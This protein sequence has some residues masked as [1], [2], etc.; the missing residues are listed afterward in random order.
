MKEEGGSVAD[1]REE[2]ALR[3]LARNVRAGGS[4]NGVEQGALAH[5]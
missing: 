3:A 4:G 2:R 5:S 1:K